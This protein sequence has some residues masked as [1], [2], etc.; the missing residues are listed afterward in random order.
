MTPAAEAV[1]TTRRAARVGRLAPGVGRA[2]ASKGEQRRAKA[3]KGEQRRA[4]ASKGEGAAI[5]AARQP[6]ANRGRAAIQPRPSLDRAE[7]NRNKLVRT[8][9]NR[10]RSVLALRSNRA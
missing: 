2:R 9:P 6:R 4:K 5:L 3:S 1:R 8:A 7:P 10:D